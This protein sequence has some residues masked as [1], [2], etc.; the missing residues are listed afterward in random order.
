MATVIKFKTTIKKAIV[1]TTTP[2]SIY[3]QIRDRYPF[4]ILLEGADYHSPEDS[5]S[6][7]CF[8]PCASFKVANET[9]FITYPGS[10]PETLAIHDRKLVTEKFSEF[11]SNFKAADNNELPPYANGVF[12]YTAYDAIRYFEELELTQPA[13]T[14]RQI[15]D[16]CYHFYEYT[17]AI[18]HFH[19]TMEL[20]HHKVDGI[21]TC[22]DPLLDDPGF[23]TQL[24]GN[25]NFSFETPG[26]EQSDFSDNEFADLVGRCQKHIQ[27]GDVFQIVPSRAF[28]QNFKG[29]DFQLYRALR[30]INPSPYLFY[31]DLG[32]FRLIGSSPEAQII[33]KNGDA[34]IHP[35]AGTYRRSGDDLA[36]AELAKRLKADEKENAEHVM[37]VDLARND[38]SIHCNRVKVKAYREVQYFSHVIHLVSIVSGTLN[39]EKDAVSVF[40]STFPAGTLSGAPKHRAMQLIDKYESGRRSF[41]GG[42]IGFLGFNGDC[43]QAIMI[44]SF[45]SKDCTL[46]YQAGAGIVADSK[47]KEEVQEI[48]NKLSA[49]RQA[50]KIANDL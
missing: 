34:E 13:D 32:S 37:L 48:N 2:V 3:S 7:I 18:N 24:S 5:Y 10:E 12:G 1:D 27:R 4:T 6:F 14:K 20:I 45:L 31:F 23:Y 35:I 22:E 28:E 19:S 42:A 33:I 40:A 15:P 41:Y 11:L 38:L 46:H 17:I 39:K 16:L 8:K 50:V 47:A 21:E 49:L 43:N 36:D 26:E 44:R 30:S 25:T 9:I 29:D